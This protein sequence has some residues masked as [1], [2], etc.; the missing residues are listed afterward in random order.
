MFCRMVSLTLGLINAIVTNR[1]KGE[2]QHS[3]NAPSM[4]M[5][6]F[7][8]YFVVP[9]LPRG[10]QGCFIGS[11]LFNCLVIYVYN[12]IILYDAPRF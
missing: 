2:H 10:F 9:L 11:F 4:I 12:N 3:A 5:I 6:S 1:G 8:F 7:S